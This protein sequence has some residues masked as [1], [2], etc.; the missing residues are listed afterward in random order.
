VRLT[1]RGKRETFVV[2]T[3]LLAETVPAALKGEL[4]IRNVRRTD[5]AK[6]LDVSSDWVRR[7]LNGSVEITLGDLDRLITA[8]QMTPQD[9]VEAAERVSTSASAG[10][11]TGARG[12]P[13]PRTT[14]I[15]E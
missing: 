6:R 15:K 9:L 11:E 14:Q 5:L 10:G 1:Y 7:R 12:R 3:Q 4:A 2:V 13:D 8:L